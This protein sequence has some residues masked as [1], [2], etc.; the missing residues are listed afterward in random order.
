[1]RHDHLF[2]F[3]SGELEERVRSQLFLSEF[4]IRKNWLDRTLSVSIKEPRR[5]AVLEDGPD[6]YWL[7][8]EGRIISRAEVSDWAVVGYPRLVNKIKKLSLEK[9]IGEVFISSI[10]WTNLFK[11]DPLLSGGPGV[12]VLS[13]EVYNP[14]QFVVREGE[15]IEKLVSA[16][17][18]AL[19]PKSLEELA[20]AVD[21]VSSDDFY[22]PELLV[23]TLPGW[24]LYMGNEPFRDPSAIEEQVL[25][26]SLLL[27]ENKFFKNKKI[28]YI[29]L[30]FINKLFFK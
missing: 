29:D 12:K 8:D 20:P 18:K 9:R 19:E 28:E 17:Q 24:I 30:R 7:S 6:L 13:F 22:Y 27:R 1:M 2:V 15:K 3:S 26:L 21:F 10:F 14:E 11:L 23:H 4:I 25:N 16:D 5:R